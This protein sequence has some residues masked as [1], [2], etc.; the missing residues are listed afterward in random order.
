MRVMGIKGIK[1]MDINSGEISEADKKELA[2]FLD[3]E[4]FIGIT[5]VKKEG[6]FIPMVFLSNT[7]KGWLEDVRGKWGG[8]VSLKRSANPKWKTAWQWHIHGDNLL[9]VL[10]AI[11]PYLKIKAESCDLCRE[12]QYR[13]SHRIGVDHSNR[14]TLQE[15]DTRGRLYRKC[16]MLTATGRK[17]EQLKMDEPIAQL[18]LGV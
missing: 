14:L 5:C 18:S 4:G 11:R 17:A 8:V 2:N 6:R 15:K 10:D 1:G 7:N 12:L 9:Q 13:I 3:T 16:K